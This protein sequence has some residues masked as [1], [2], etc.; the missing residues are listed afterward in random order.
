VVLLHGGGIDGAWVSWRHL[1]PA[2]AHKHYVLAPD[3]PGYGT[4][5]PPPPDQPYTTEYLVETV[6][7]FLDVLETDGGRPKPDGDRPKTD[8]DR[9][10]IASDRPQTDGDR[11]KTN[12]VALVG[13]S[14]G[15]AAALGTALAQ[16]E[17]VSKLVLIDSYGLQ[18]T[19]PWRP[20]SVWALRAPGPLADVAWWLVE[21][22]AIIR[23]AGLSAIF[24]DPRRLTAEILADATDNV[25]LPHF[26][27][28][29]CDELAT[30]RARTDYT[31]QLPALDVPTLLIHGSHD[32][33]IPLQW[34]RQ[35][36][37]CLPHSD[38]VV[39]PGTGHWPNRERPHAVNEAVVRFLAGLPPQAEASS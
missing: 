13:L 17:R 37:A 9:P 4:S 11:P 31:A 32:P 1:I 36:A 33:S 20:F 2:L 26:Y 19:P 38:L 8:A 14:M 5:A 22:F 29:L 15:G 27:A 23:R 25:R 3:L 35:A 30:G 18:A 28:W 16:P 10:E 24:R 34:A 12:T 39:I 6:T 21:R 7:A